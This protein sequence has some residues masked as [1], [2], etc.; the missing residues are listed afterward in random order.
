MCTKKE[1]QA[2]HRLKNTTQDIIIFALSAAIMFVQQIVLAGLPNIELVSLLVIV[3]ARIFRYKSMYIIY[4]FVLL[5]GILYGFHLWWISYLYVWT[6]LAFITIMLHS[7]KSVFIWAAISGIFGLLFGVL[8]A[9][10]YLITGGLS[11]ALAY[12][13]SGIP[14]DIIHCVGNFVLCLLL[15]KPLIG[16]LSKIRKRA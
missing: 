16:L 15:W 9:I 1:P 5:E 3:Y 14:F 13:V 6:I 8:C 7:V 10:P 12:W 4:I 11:M 2:L